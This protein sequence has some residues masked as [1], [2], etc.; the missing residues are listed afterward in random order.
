MAFLL[1]AAVAL[2][3]AAV[4]ELDAAAVALLEAVERSGRSAWS[5]RFGLHKRRAPPA[6]AERRRPALEVKKV[7][8]S[9]S[10]T[11][12]LALVHEFPALC[13]QAGERRGSRM[14]TGER[15]GCMDARPRSAG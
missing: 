2:L 7:V 11:Q 12:R 13:E 15:R 3:E 14:R 6:A 8:P 5:M 1:V 10:H 4:S 9:C